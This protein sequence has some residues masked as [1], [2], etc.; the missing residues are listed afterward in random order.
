MTMK[1]IKWDGTEV[2]FNV[3]KI[4]A[5]ITK[6]NE[7]TSGNIELTNGQINSIASHIFCNVKELKRA[8]TVEEIQELVETELMKAGAYETAKRYI[9]YRYNRSLAVWRKAK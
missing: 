3:E 2:D 4:S 6:A 7:A 8:P 1:I 9:R 5:A